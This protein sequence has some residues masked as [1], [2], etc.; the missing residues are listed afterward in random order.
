MQNS[1]FTVSIKLFIATD[2][3]E[4]SHTLHSTLQKNV[5]EKIQR[6]IF[7]NDY[8]FVYYSLLN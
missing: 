3:S 6:E 1:L 8:I 5:I 4:Q 7:C 2:H